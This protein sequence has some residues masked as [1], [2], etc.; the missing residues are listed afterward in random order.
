MAILPDHRLLALG[1]TLISPFDESKVQPASIDVTLDKAFY[2]AKTD[3]AAYILDPSVA[4]DDS[5][6]LV[7]ETP[8]GKPFVL[9]PRDFALASTMEVVTLP[10]DLVARFEGKSSLGRLGLLTHITAGFIDPGFSGHITLE[11]RNLT[12]FRIFLWPGMSI[13]QV[14]FEEMLEPVIR[15][16]GDEGN[17][18]HYQGQRGPTLS[19]SYINF[20]KMNVYDDDEANRPPV[21]NDDPTGN[22]I[23]PT[24]DEKPEKPEKPESSSGSGK[25][26]NNV[27]AQNEEE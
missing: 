13:G 19:K 12:N 4:S 5:F 17:G 18:S 2:R 21:I 25:D 27:A 22:D 20:K 24:E 7:E 14:C 10:P 8:P 16:Y 6:E 1:S 26:K 3:T 15:P 9:N 23:P 11:L